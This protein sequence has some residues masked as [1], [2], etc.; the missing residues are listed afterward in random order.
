[1]LGIFVALSSMAGKEDKSGKGTPG[2]VKRDLGPDNLNME[3]YTITGEKTNLAAFKGKA[4][5]IVNVAS[6]CGFTPQYS[7]LE[8]LYGKYRDKGLVVV[9]F[10]AN[11][12]G[13][14]EPGTNEEI[15]DFCRTRYDVSFPMMSKISVK[16]EDKHPLFVNLTEKSSMPGEIKWNFF[17]FLLDGNG[18]LVARFP[19]QTK[20][21]DKELTDQI[22][23]L[24]D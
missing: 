21:L 2:M 5:L 9:G 4:Y 6:K 7:G 10:P 3:L 18:E 15:L 12:F 13:N 24:L 11:N 17:K 16:G 1:M 8:E 20:P 22:D 23:K 14:Q 19:S